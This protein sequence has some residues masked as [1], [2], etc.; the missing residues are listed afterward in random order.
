MFTSR[1]FCSRCPTQ[2]LVVKRTQ[3]SFAWKL[4]S[5]RMPARPAM[6]G[7]NMYP[8][9]TS[10]PMLTSWRSQ[11]ELRRVSPLPFSLALGSV[12]ARRNAEPDRCPFFDLDSPGKLSPSNSLVQARARP[13]LL[14]SGN[15]HATIVGPKDRGFNCASFEGSRPSSVP[16]PQSRA[17]CFRKCDDR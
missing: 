7:A 12:E 13:D 11:S 8:S 16:L 14:I 10:D 5:K 2:R 6:H 9:L 15:L 4:L 17:T 3:I 1:Q